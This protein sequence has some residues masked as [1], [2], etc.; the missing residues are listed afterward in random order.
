MK[1]LFF[2]V[3]LTFSLL[4]SDVAKSLNYHTD[5]NTALKAALKADKPLMLVQVT[6]YCPW[7]RKLEKNTLSDEDIKKI[8]S[9]KF[10]PLLVL[11]DKSSFPE[12]FR[13]PRIPTIF[14]IEAKT[15]EGY[16]ESIGYVKK[17][18]MLTNLETALELYNE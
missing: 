14:F 8:V 15:E 5:Y 2:L 18:E 3:A 11:R 17:D 1:A 6:D 10:I 7:C 9:E 4:G 13:T 12:K 16:W